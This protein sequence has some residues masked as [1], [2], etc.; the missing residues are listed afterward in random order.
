[1][2]QAADRN[3]KG[4]TGSARGKIQKINGIVGGG[5]CVFAD[6]ICLGKSGHLVVAKCCLFHRIIVDQIQFNIQLT[7]SDDRQCKRRLVG[8]A[9]LCR[10]EGCK[11]N[12]I[13]FRRSIHIQRFCVAVNRIG[14]C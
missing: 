6:Q 1:M 3:G 12:L 10:I 13:L 4:F 14:G 7:L 5:N 8:I 11:V 2:C 9:K